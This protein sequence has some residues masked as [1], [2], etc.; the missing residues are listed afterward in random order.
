M[1]LN[2]RA[3][4]DGLRAVAVLAVLFYHANIKIF[5]GGF[6]G[7]DIFFVISGYL[8]TTIILREI[9]E[10][11]FSIAKFYERRIRRIFPA[12]FTMLIATIIISGWLFSPLVFKDVSQS[13]I[14]TTLFGSNILFWTQSGYFEAPSIL[15]PLLHTWSLAVEEQFYIFF[16]LLLVLLA[17]YLRSRLNLILLAITIGSLSWSI[18]VL[19]YDDSAAFYLAHL[20]TWELLIGSLLATKIITTKI[21]LQVANLLGLLG[22]TMLAGSIFL[23]TNNTN[24]PGL[25]AL[26]PTLGAALIIYSGIENK[27]FVGRILSFWPVVFVGQISYS[28]YLWHWPIL[29]FAK[30]YAITPLQPSA[31]IAVIAGSFVLAILSWRF[32]EKPFRE[33]TLLQNRKSIFASAALVMGLAIAAGLVI[34][35]SNGLPNL[36]A[37]AKIKVDPTENEQSEKW[38]NCTDDPQANGEI[39]P[40]KLCK[41]GNRMDTASFL[42]WG[43]SHARAIAPAIQKS[44]SYAD[45]AGLTAYRNLCFPLLGIDL[46]G[47]DTCSDFNDHVINYIREHPNLRKIILVS[48]WAL[49]ATGSRYKNEIGHRIVL[50]NITPTDF[51]ST[52]PTNPTTNEALFTL[53]LKRTIDTLLGM[54]RQVII[55]TQTPEVGYNVPS[56]F[57]IA[58]RTSRDLNKIIAPS[59]SEYFGRNTI[60][61][62]VIKSLAQKNKNVQIANPWKILCNAQ[63]CTVVAKNQALYID[64]DHLSVFGAEYISDIF[65]PIFKN[66]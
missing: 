63:T 43:D 17:R 18:Y 11:T 12:L 22:L 20:R 48:R 52:T 16:P 53:G 7:V 30:Y 29:V 13:V 28:L 24:F 38:Q 8:I 40:L 54:G 66:P 44:A 19:N 49:A 41:I 21:N 61:A 50:A 27:T 37:Q 26:L 46:K 2:Y 15:K 59:R 55:V 39:I 33:K 31:L 23:Y 9:D 32:V 47:Q 3:D 57:S 60:D 34:Y 10:N 62:A 25:A 1:K 58:Q 65:Y 4:I 14:A 56:A 51:P 5:S 45:V 42:L 35:L 36:L 64:D 6:V